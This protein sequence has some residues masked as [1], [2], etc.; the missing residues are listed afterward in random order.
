M[1]F[2]SLYLKTYTLIKYVQYSLF[3]FVLNLNNIINY[4]LLIIILVREVYQLFYFEHPE[5]F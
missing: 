3:L 1:N 5:E 2:F 4:L